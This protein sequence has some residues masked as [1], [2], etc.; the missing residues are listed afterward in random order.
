MNCHPN[1]AF[2]AVQT[3]AGINDV[4][5]AGNITWQGAC[6]VSVSALQFPAGHAPPQQLVWFY[7]DPF[8]KCWC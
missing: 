7:L 5:T 6:F 3:P 2:R 4:P 1:A 8:G